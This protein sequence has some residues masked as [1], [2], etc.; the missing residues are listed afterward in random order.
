MEDKAELKVE[1]Q[2]A[3]PNES[4]ATKKVPEVEEKKEDIVGKVKVL[5]I[6]V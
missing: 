6:C 5:V 4:E 3:E 1:V 2:A